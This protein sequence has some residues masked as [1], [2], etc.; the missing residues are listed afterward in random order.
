MN[1]E[2]MEAWC[3][4][5]GWEPQHGGGFYNRAT[6]TLF[7]SAQTFLHFDIRGGYDRGRFRDEWCDEHTAAFSELLTQLKNP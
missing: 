6:N 7:T 1:R 5:E 2:Q 3:A 4:L